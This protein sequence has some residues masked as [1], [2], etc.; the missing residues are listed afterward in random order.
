[1]SGPTLREDLD[2][3]VSFIS[4][5]SPWYARRFAYRIV[6][7]TRHLS[8]FP[9]IGRVIP[10]VKNVL[11]REIIVEG[12]RVMYRIDSHR[13]LILAVVHGRRDPGSQSTPP[14]HRP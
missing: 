2:E 8:E 5:N 10:E 9:Q 11:L 7:S 3:L 13:V 4:R 6:Y 12:Y 1:L 14:W